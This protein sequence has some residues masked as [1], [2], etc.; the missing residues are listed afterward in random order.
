MLHEHTI[1]QEIQNI[2][3]N[4]IGKTQ[5][6][7]LHVRPTSH[8]PCKILFF[9]SLMNSDMEYNDAEI[10][11]GVLHMV[12][13]LDD[14][15]VELLFAR[16]KM[17]IEGD[18]R[19]VEGLNK[20]L[21][22]I[23][24]KDQDDIDLI[25]ITLLEGYWEGVVRLIEHIRNVG[26]RARIAIG[27]VMPTLTPEHVAI[28]LKGISFVCRGA[29]EYFLPKLVQILGKTNIDTPLTDRQIT[30]FA[31]MDGI[32]VLEEFR[33]QNQNENQKR[34]ICGRSDKVV[35]VEDLSKVAL[36]LN[37]VHADFN[38]NFF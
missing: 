34:L 36:N 25:C 33:N 19:P 35:Q 15:D 20:S 28:H 8:S 3:P 5:I 29:G 32:I 11:Q 22:D 31:H 23:F 10:S 9:E 14:L 37:Y 1:E 6:Q 17:P 4:Q 21:T 2:R 16:V 7:N 27:G 26:S 18:N 30:D 12:S 38:E 24:D 13:S